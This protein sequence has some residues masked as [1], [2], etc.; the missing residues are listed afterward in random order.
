MEREIIKYTC[1]KCGCETSYKNISKFSESGEC[2]K[3]GN[4]TYYKKT[5]EYDLQKPITVKCPYCNST[6][7]KKIS[8][9][10]KAGNVALFGIFSMGKVTKQWHCNDCKSDF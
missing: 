1:D 10:T 5:K 9:A 6:N 4:M 3:C 7:T 2:T 8:S